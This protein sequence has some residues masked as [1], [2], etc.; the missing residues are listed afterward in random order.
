MLV[1]LVVLV[2]VGS[3]MGA[4]VVVAGVV[5]VGLVVGGVEWLWLLLALALCGPITCTFDIAAYLA[6]SV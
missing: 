1:V 5:F 4:L 6:I 3:L 2:L